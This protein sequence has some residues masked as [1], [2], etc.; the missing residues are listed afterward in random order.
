MIPIIFAQS[1]LTFPALAASFFVQTAVAEDGEGF[2]VRLARIISQGFTQGGD[3]AV[4]P[5]AL[6]FFW[7]LMFLA[8][9]GFTFFYTDVMVRQQRLAQSLQQ[10]GGFIPGIRPGKK[11]DDYLMA[12]T[13]R[14]TLVGAVFL[15]LVAILPGIL[16]F[17]GYFLDIS[18]LAQSALVITGSG[19]IIVVGVVIDTMRQIEAQLIMRNYESSMI[20]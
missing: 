9:V 10:R 15:G 6:A 17:L 1:I 2:G 18:G 14:I 7:V 11:T 16:Q 8:V 19:L 5:G 3:P 13:R 20:G 4:Y 12:V